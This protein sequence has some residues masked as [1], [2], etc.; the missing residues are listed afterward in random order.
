[1]NWFF[2]GT[3]NRKVLIFGAAAALAVFGSVA[4]SQPASAGP[5]PVTVMAV[6]DIAC[7]P[8]QTNFNDGAGTMAGCRQQAVSDVV[9]SQDADAFIPLGDI[10]Y[11]DGRLEA[12]QQSYD[13]SFGDLKSITR[14]VPGNHEYNQPYGAGYYAYFGDAA[15]QETKGSYSYDIGDWHVVAINSVMCTPSKPCGPGSEMARWLAADAAANTKSCTMAVWHHPLWSAGNHGG[16]TPMIP[17]WNQLNSYG[18]DM[19]LT[20]HDHMYQRFQPIGEASLTADGKLSAPVVTENGM[21]EYV[22]GTGGE[23]NYDP[24]PNA[25]PQ[26]VSALAAT[27]SN[28]NPAVF[29][30]LKLQLDQ[31]SYQADFVPAQG[32]TFTDSASRGCRPKTPPAGVPTVP[33]Q[34]TAARSG[35][36]KATISWQVPSMP[37]GTPAV[38]YSVS[39]VGSA[40]KCSPVSG[41]SCMI[42]GLTNGRTYQFQVTASNAVADVKSELTP[43]L[44]V[45][46]Q[47]TKPGTPVVVLGASSATLT[48]TAPTYDGG[49]PITRFDAFSTSGGKSCVSTGPLT[50]T[51]TGLVPGTRYSFVVTATNEA[52]TSLTSTG[53]TAVVA[54]S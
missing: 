37:A 14:P 31:G 29:G 53:S 23:D 13:R 30:A 40:K 10:Q 54:R 1:M 11:Q 25:D 42:T 17:V 24:N 51:I 2:G 36:G 26:L 34:V 33:S 6:G 12:F 35:D 27:A 5:D 15:H 8:L 3:L 32:T 20:G 50:C 9:R 49:L 46:M 52:G 39:P 28:P 48:W 41:N 16:Y 38:T 19:V 7:D 18:T 22:V 4:L 47:P 45:G 21:V 43:P 44:Q